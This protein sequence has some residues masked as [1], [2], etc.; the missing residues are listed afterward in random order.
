MGPQVVSLLVL[1]VA[2]LAKGGE[3]Q[4]PSKSLEDEVPALR[5]LGPPDAPRLPDHFGRCANGA[6]FEHSDAEL[7]RTDGWRLGTMFPAGEFR[8]SIGSCSF[9][10][11]PLGRIQG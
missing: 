3:K 6:G 4:V 1:L 7:A 9:G 10:L 11:D 8:G 5:D 2:V